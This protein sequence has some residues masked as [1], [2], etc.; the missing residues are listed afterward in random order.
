MRIQPILRPLSVGLLLA[1]GLQA[2]AGKA[3]KG[4]AR[5]ASTRLRLGL[6]GLGAGY[7]WYDPFL[8][9]G[10]GYGAFCP[11]P[12]LWPNGYWLAAN[13]SPPPGTARLRVTPP[14]ARV[15]IDSA[16]AGTVEELR[17]L[18]LPPGAYLV[19]FD[20]EGFQTQ[21]QKVYVLSGKTMRLDVTLRLEP[22]GGKP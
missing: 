3:P 12:T 19:Q 18:R 10:L 17:D 8:W 13:P 16:F 6:V 2:Q 5:A 1:A 11:Y 7:G 14:Q 4:D 21:Q 9:G 15:T 22:Q 20:L